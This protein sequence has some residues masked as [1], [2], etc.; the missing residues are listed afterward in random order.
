[1]KVAKF[2]RRCL[3]QQ[4]S[5]FKAEPLSHLACWAVFFVLLL[6]LPEQAGIDELSLVGT[7]LALVAAV[8]ISNFFRRRD[9][10]GSSL[11]SWERLG[12]LVFGGAILV[13]LLR[14]VFPDALSGS[15]FLYYLILPFVAWQVGFFLG[16]H[17]K[18]QRKQEGIR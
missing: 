11:T 1:M 16:E 12:D 13:V 6:W 15:G 4:W 18:K 8:F 14:L 9:G 10:E 7:L 5:G 3:L 2:F 17:G